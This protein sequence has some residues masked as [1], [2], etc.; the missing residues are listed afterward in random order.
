MSNK[1]R[2]GQELTLLGRPVVRKVVK[3]EVLSEKRLRDL[4][5]R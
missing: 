4:Q 1:Y 3:E 5:G 2:G